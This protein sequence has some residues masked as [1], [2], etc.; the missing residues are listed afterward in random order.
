MS[1]LSLGWIGLG[2]MG[3]PIVKN[4][5]R[6]GFSVTVYNRTK[7]KDTE[8]VSA[9]ATT[10]DTAR[11]LA[12]NCDVIL[13]M[14]S[15]DDAVKQIFS[16]EDGLL[17]TSLAGKLIIDM[18]TVSPQ[19]SR[20]LNDLCKNSGADFLDAPVSG[21]VKP[22]QDAT[23]IVMVGGEAGAYN[24]AQPV[25]D[26]M[27][28][29]AMHLGESGTG[30]SAKLAINYFLAVTMQGLSETVLFARTLGI[31]TADMLTIVNEGACSSGITKIKSQNILDDNFSA[32]F[33][34]KHLAKDLRL[35]YEQG[36]DSP[37]ISPILNS[38][39]SAF[40]KGYGDDDAIAIFKFLD[41]KPLA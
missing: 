36:L 17:S 32:A 20:E 38:Y 26:A 31:D 23:L 35:A 18:S 14:V 15:D 2:H 28:K 3:N 6:A 41:T 25:F 19:T 30:S 29:L 33:P 16:G 9:G 40:N 22:A 8:V 34:L 12:E 7:G 5:L 21:S 4:L 39:Q 37:L 24:K 27:S 10:A 1:K 11:Q 13:T